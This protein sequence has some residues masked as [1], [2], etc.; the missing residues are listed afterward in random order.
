MRKRR[1]TESKKR[2]FSDLLLAFSINLIVTR[3][4]QVI[5]PFVGIIFI[6]NKQGKL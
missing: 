6:K 5:D 1:K 4:H 3:K 2:K